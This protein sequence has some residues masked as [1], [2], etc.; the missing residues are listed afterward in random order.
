[1]TDR[2]RVICLPPPVANQ[3]AAGEVVTRPS[4]VVKEL[5][6]N[7]IDAEATRIAVDI[8]GGGVTRIRVVDDG[9]GM[10]RDDAT[11]ALQRHATS[12]IRRAE[13]LL[14][15]RSF[16]FRGEALPSIASVSRFRLRT[17]P[18]DEEEGTEVTLEGGVNLDVRPC[19]AAPG[20]TVEVEDLFFNVPA[21]R[22]FLRATSTESAHV[23]DALKAIALA[24]PRIQFDIT[25]DGR[26]RHRWLS[27]PKRRERVQN[28]FESYPLHEA[29]GDRGPVSVEGYLS[30]PDRARTGAGGLYLFV[31]DRPVQDRA[32]ARAV[33]TAYGPALD[34]G[35]YPVGAVFLDVDPTLVDVNVHPQKTEVR[36]AHARAVADALHGVVADALGMRCSGSSR[37]PAWSRSAPAPA[38]AP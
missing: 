26:R 18:A 36:F 15:I 16:G 12:K 29:S 5:V 17:R 10:V 33:A 8:D 27:A 30:T 22:K 3:I 9:I 1:M 13:D 31:R 6:E 24:H 21:R 4:S 34:P 14:T 19:G 11:R 25:R 38:P 35:R 20:T 32:L 2:A 23:G 37:A 28:I 7:A